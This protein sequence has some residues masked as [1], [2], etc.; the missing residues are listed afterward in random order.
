VTAIGRKINDG[1][2]GLLGVLI[3]DVKA[4]V[5]ELKMKGRNGVTLYSD[6]LRPRW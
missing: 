2:E 5:N 6:C 4:A 1:K 3:A